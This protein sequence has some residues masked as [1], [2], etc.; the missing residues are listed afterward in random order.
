MILWH[1]CY[2]HKTDLLCTKLTWWPLIIVSNMM[3]WFKVMTWWSYLVRSVTWW[4]YFTMTNMMI[5]FKTDTNLSGLVIE[6]LDQRWNC[7]WKNCYRLT[8][9]TKIDVINQENDK[10]Y[11]SFW[12]LVLISKQHLVFFLLLRKKSISTMLRNCQFFFFISPCTFCS[13]FIKVD[14][15]FHQFELGIS[16]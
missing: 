1:R 12:K 13:C 11:Q 2:G 9:S 4:P 16:F 10:T 5:S 8:D 15:C 14:N 3:A 7:K 6:R